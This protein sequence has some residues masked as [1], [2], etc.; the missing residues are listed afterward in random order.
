MMRA[1]TRLL[2]SNSNTSSGNGFRDRVVVITGASAGVGRATARAFAQAGARV[3]LIARDAAALEETKAEIESLGGGAEVFA[4]DVADPEVLT[5]AAEAFEASLGPIEVWVNCAMVTVFSP[6]SKLSA[7]EVKRVTEVTYLGTV[8]G[9]LAALAHMRP[10]D[11]GTIVQVGSALAYR[12]IP[13]QS[14]YCAAK[15]AVRGFTESLRSELIHEGS[16]I[17]VTEVHLPAINTPQ[18]DWARARHGGKPRPVPPIFQPEEAAEA[19]VHAAAK[20]GEREYWLGRSTASAILANMLAPFY[21]D[22]Y[23]AR[24]A[25]DAQSAKDSGKPYTRDNLFKPEHGLH[26]TR[27]SYGHLATKGATLLPGNATRVAVVVGGCAISAAAGFMLAGLLEG[28][29]GSVRERVDS[30]R[31]RRPG[32]K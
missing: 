27:G 8:H 12:S 14:A 29:D 31:H 18:F 7:E 6:I 19:I 13:L 11:V 20:P 2:R 1:L 32:R 5:R 22:R 16:H 9:T 10:R 30:S 17:A 3:G 24:F 23:L 15:H 4:G 25:V 26:R 21:L 28:R